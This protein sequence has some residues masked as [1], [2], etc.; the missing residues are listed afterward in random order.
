MRAE[1]T[2]CCSAEWQPRHSC[3]WRPRN[4]GLVAC[5]HALPAGWLLWTSQHGPSCSVLRCRREDGS[6]D[7]NA[8][9]M[10]YVAPMKVGV[11]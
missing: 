2:Q 8:F 5:V 3:K 9:K 4:S 10:V 6:I 7:K 1:C 11:V